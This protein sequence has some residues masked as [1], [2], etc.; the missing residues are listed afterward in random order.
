M[1]AFTGFAGTFFRTRGGAGAA[2]VVFIVASYVMDFIGSAA[3]DS[4]IAPLRSLSFF[5]YYDNAHIMQT[6]LNIPN[7]ALLL[8]LSLVLVAGS[9]WFFQRRDVGI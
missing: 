2:A 6:G 3:S 5:A 4:F 9:V 1:L 7:I 8:G